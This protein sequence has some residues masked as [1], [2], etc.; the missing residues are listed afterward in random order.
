MDTIQ[1]DVNLSFQQLI[2][3][4]KKLSPSERLKLNDAIWDE[5]M[6]I[7]EA[8]QKIVGERMLKSKQNPKRL[9]DW[10]AASKTLK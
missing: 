1:L 4:V 6:E 2:D 9:L 8:Q 10:N 7:P 3:A 5:N